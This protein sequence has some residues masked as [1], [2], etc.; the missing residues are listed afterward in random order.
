VVLI[1]VGLL[2]LLVE[3]LSYADIRGQVA[4]PAAASPDSTATPS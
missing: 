1:A 4:L 3:G 2:G